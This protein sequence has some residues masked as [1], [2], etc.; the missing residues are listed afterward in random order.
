MT[1]DEID[2]AA[3]DRL[4]EGFLS[5]S[6]ANGP[7]WRSRS[8]LASYDFTYGERIGWKWDA[9][10]RELRSPGLL[11]DS[12]NLVSTRAKRMTRISAH[13]GNW[14]AHCQVPCV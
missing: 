13:C 2:W 3:L 4:R 7:Y 11:P 1:W 14:E 10:L 6:A 8:D 5:G 12:T 9:V